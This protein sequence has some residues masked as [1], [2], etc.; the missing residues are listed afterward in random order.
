MD[1]TA[2][3]EKSL[4]DLLADASKDLAKLGIKSQRVASILATT[5][6]PEAEDLVETLDKVP[7]SPKITPRVLNPQT[8]RQC[9][10]RMLTRSR[11]TNILRSYAGS[12]T[13]VT[14][15]PCRVSYP[16]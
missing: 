1:I 10:P 8:I 16:M 7:I 12:V 13:P 6:Q 9:L 14:P 11:R 2:D 4:S 5:S 3:E 15:Y